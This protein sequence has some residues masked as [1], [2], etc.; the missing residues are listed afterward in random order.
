MGYR[1]E[2]NSLIAKDDL[3]GLLKK[4]ALFHGHICSFS[5]YGVKAGYY[6]MKQ[7][8]LTSEGMEEVLS[9]VETNNCFSDGI[10][11]T[12]GCTFGNNGL[13]FHDKGKTAVTVIHRKSKDSIRLSLK[14]DFLDSRTEVYPVVSSLF[15][16]IV[17]KREN[18]STSE[19]QEFFKLSEDMAI[20]E[21]KI[22]ETEMFDIT[23][24]MVEPPEY[25]PIFDSVICSICGEKIM[26]SR[27][28]VK[29][30][31][32]ACITCKGEWFFY[33]DGH[34]ISLKK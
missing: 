26:E 24:S 20:N 30:G 27:A 31:K 8:A 4:S 1:D 2:I 28:R 33:M 17:R 34:G 3:I 12:T 9:I 5:A 15:E 11:V 13:I 21:L 22:P 7:L 16:R 18:V 29:D 10:Q 25:A 14:K 23:G 32:P 6:A 19:R